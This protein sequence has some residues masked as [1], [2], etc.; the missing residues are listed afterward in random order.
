M[1]SS[2]LHKRIYKVLY[3]AAYPHVK[4]SCNTNRWVEDMVGAMARA[5]EMLIAERELK[6]YEERPKKRREPSA[7]A[8]MDFAK[9]V[10]KGGR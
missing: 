6:I 3:E 4:H 10:A 1:P 9:K 8:V 5:A 2:E 7:K